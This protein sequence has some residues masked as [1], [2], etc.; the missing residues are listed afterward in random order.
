MPIGSTTLTEMKGKRVHV[1]INDKLGFT[2]FLTDITDTFIIIDRMI[3]LSID[4]IK[5]VVPEPF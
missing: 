2:G 5:D 3:Y 1:R 4:T